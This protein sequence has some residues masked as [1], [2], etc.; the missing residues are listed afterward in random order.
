MLEDAIKILDWRTSERITKSSNSD[1]KYDIKEHTRWLLSNFKK[2]D[3]YHWIVQYKRKDIGYFNF[4]EWNPKKKTTEWGFYVGEEKA[5]GV[6]YLVAPL[7][8]NFAFNV[9]GVEKVFSRVWYNNPRIIDFHIKQGSRFDPRRDFVITK[10]GKEI[11][12]VCLSLDHND[13]KSSKFSNLKQD[14][15][16]TRWEASPF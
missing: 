12:F 16:I 4:M 5:L 11:L 15:P 8:Y 1:F 9:L 14:L 3:S 10:N 13:F 7:F 6:G 2:P